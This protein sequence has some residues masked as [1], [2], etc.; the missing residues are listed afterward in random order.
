MAPWRLPPALWLELAV[1]VP[2]KGFLVVFFFCKWVCHRVRLRTWVR[3]SLT[4]QGQRPSSDNN[5]EEGADCDIMI[6]MR[7]CRVTG[8]VL[9]AY[10]A[11][12]PIS[13]NT[14]QGRGF[15]SLLQKSR[16]ILRN[17]YHSSVML[18]MT[19]A[20]RKADVKDWA[21]TEERHF[22]VSCWDKPGSLHGK[23]VLELNKQELN[24]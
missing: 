6:T 22:L 13:F 17:H 7:T 24:T 14:L 10:Q 21:R 8:P 19:N 2:N 20:T 1:P 5:G 12:S 9:G 16:Q 11:P 4:T 23:G 18:A 3:K 15:Y